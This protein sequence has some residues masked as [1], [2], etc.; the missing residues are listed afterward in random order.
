[1][2]V[3]KLC[4]SYRT[5]L[6]TCLDML[7]FILWICFV[8]IFVKSIISYLYSWWKNDKSL[9]MKKDWKV[10]EQIKRVGKLVECLN[11]IIVILFTEIEYES[12]INFDWAKIVIL[13]CDEL[14]TKLYDCF[15]N[16]TVGTCQFRLD[17]KH[18]S[19]Y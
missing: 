6:S 2:P 7:I 14:I 10:E 11:N 5:K 1:M 16:R 13:V 9:L 4:K 12:W 19:I 17:D 15:I 18:V 8:S 3:F